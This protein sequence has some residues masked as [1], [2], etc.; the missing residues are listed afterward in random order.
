MN[1]DGMRVCDMI[2]GML[3]GIMLISIIYLYVY[4]RK[5]AKWEHRRSEI[6]YT[7][8]YLHDELLQLSECVEMLTTVRLGRAMSPAHQVLL[9]Q[10]DV[11]NK[12][13]EI[14]SVSAEA[15]SLYK[16]VWVPD[17]E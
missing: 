6:P 16:D 13:A 14:A 2:M 15:L 8:D 7:I 9:Q 3:M 5:Y 12:F 17:K 4:S 1:I 10:S 11:W